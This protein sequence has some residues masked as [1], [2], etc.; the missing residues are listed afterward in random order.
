MNLSVKRPAGRNC[1]KF[2]RCKSQVLN[3]YQPLQFSARARPANRTLVCCPNFD[4]ASIGREN[5]APVKTSSVIAI[6][7]AERAVAI[8]DIGILDR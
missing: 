1:F 3:R 7:E 2:F 4:A 8:L 5:Q 6:R